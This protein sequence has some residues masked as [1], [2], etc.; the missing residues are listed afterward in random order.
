MKKIRDMLLVIV[1]ICVAGV[2]MVQFHLQ[3]FGS[4][5]AASGPTPVP[6]LGPVQTEK[7][8][9]IDGPQQI[10]GHWAKVEG[11]YQYPQCAVVPNL[12]IRCYIRHA[13]PQEA[14]RR[15][16]LSHNLVVANLRACRSSSSLWIYD[17]DWDMKPQFGEEHEQFLP[18]VFEVYAV[19]VEEEDSANLPG[20]R[21]PYYIVAASSEAFLK[22]V[23]PYV[24]RRS[25]ASIS[26]PFRV[27]RTQ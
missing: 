13:L 2:L 12:T 23:T 10:T 5:V 26:G 15:Y 25:R 20:S 27:K 9:G 6:S 3:V 17:G 7:L 1:L 8:I 18:K 24:Y 21:E 16:W 14:E 11:W 19:L 22:M 4:K